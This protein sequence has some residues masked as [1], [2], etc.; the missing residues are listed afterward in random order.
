M[1]VNRPEKR[2][3]SARGPQPVRGCEEG[4]PSQKPQSYLE[5]GLFRRYREARET[6]TGE[7]SGCSSSKKYEGSTP[8]N[9]SL[10]WDKPLCYLHLSP[11][12]SDESQFYTPN[13]SKSVSPDI[14]GIKNPLAIP[15]GTTIITNKYSSKCKSPSGS[16][17][18]S[19]FL[20]RV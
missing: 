15:M 16:F 7:S 17:S 6:S 11:T 2:S 1:N 13:I 8:E 18:E 14:S 5:E 3:K 12:P 20:P 4:D 10:Q 9:H 19:S